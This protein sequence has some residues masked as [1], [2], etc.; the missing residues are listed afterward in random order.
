MRKQLYRIKILKEPGEFIKSEILN[1]KS[2]ISLWDCCTG[3]GGK[4]I[5]AFDIDPKIKLTVF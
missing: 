2:E 4:S 5:M 3:S 1:L